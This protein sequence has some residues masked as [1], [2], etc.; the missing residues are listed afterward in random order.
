VHVSWNIKKK[1]GWYQYK[2]NN[3]NKNKYNNN[4][5]YNKQY[6]DIN[7]AGGGPQKQFTLLLTHHISL[8]YVSYL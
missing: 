8:G 3:N 5:Y 7:E 6:G 4:N 2:I 1:R